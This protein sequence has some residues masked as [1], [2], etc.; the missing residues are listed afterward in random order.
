MNLDFTIRSI[1]AMAFYAEYKHSGKRS[2]TLTRRK[3]KSV[4]DETRHRSNTL[5]T[6]DYP[7]HL[8]RNARSKSLSTVE[9]LKNSESE[10]TMTTINNNTINGSVSLESFSSREGGSIDSDYGAFDIVGETNSS[11]FP[12]LRDVTTQC[13]NSRMVEKS[14]QTEPILTCEQCDASESMSGWRNMER[15][16]KNGLLVMHEHNGF[17]Y[18][19]DVD[20]FN[21]VRPQAVRSGR[22]IKRMGS[23][24]E[25]GLNIYRSDETV[26]PPLSPCPSPIMNFKFNQH[27]RVPSNPRLVVTLDS[28][29]DYSYHEDTQSSQESLCSTNSSLRPPSPPPSAL[30][31]KSSRDVSTTE[32]VSEIEDH[33]P[34]SIARYQRRRGAVT[35]KMRPESLL[36]DEIPTVESSASVVGDALCDT[37]TPNQGPSELLPR[38]SI[39]S[40]EGETLGSFAAV[41]LTDYLVRQATLGHEEGESPDGAERSGNSKTKNFLKKLSGKDRDRESRIAMATVLSN[42]PTKEQ[43]IFDFVAFKDSH[44]TDLINVAHPEGAVPLSPTSSEAEIKRRDHVWEVFTSECSY[45]VDHLLVLRDVFQETFKAVQCENHLMY[46]EPAKLFANLD[47]LCQVSESFC[48]DLF[49]I[50]RGKVTSTEFGQPECV[51]SAFSMF[52]NHVCPPYERYCMNYS[53]ALHYLESLKKRED[54]QEVVRWCELNP[55]CKRLQMSDFL[56]APIQ[57]ITKYPILLNDILKRTTS[58]ADKTALT[59]T[60]ENVKFALGELEGKVRWLTNFERM[61]ELQHMITWTIDDQD[62]KAMLPEFMKNSILEKTRKSLSSLFSGTKRALIYEGPLILTDSGKNIDIYAFIFDDMFLMTKIKKDAKKKASH[63]ERLSAQT[64]TPP[65]PRRRDGMMFHVYK[66]PIPLDRLD[67]VEVNSRQA[68]ASGMK[69][70]FVMMHTSRYQQ[71]LSV[72]TV[73]TPNEH[74]KQTWI[75]ELNKARKTRLDQMRE[76]HHE[77]RRTKDRKK[78]L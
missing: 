39:K 49:V 24:S 56:V 73:M 26:S 77:E 20:Q 34:Q 36:E 7:S 51:V 74:S 53:N 19:A 43:E 62:A 48:Q 54:F 37:L 59:E 3:A 18:G 5:G 27:R 41:H 8:Q 33:E 65:V 57:R 35:S 14:V 25:N 78:T 9:H 13:G 71:I 61:R 42:L 55:R 63:F 2:R 66:Q 10:F 1:P 29:S 68:Q 72:Y 50:L 30:R 47:V 28:D 31:C 60:I 11:R 12:W 64:H 4:A 70:A 58:P 44:W 23:S 76:S 21:A 40:D 75:K 15:I 52:D 38:L 67:V 45:L 46:V 17:E 69:Y 6:N 22:M 16:R 32:P